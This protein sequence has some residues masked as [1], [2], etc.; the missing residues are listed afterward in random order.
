MLVRLDRNEM[1]IKLPREITDPIKESIEFL[2]R[3]TPQ[4]KV[5]ELLSSLS[6]YTNS[7]KK[8]IIISSASDI[9]LKEFIYLFSRNRQIILADPSF[10]LINATCRKIYSSILKVRLKEPEFKFSIVPLIDDLK[11][12]TLIILDNP[13]N[14]T[15]NI[16]LDKNE[17]KLI[18]E[19]ENIIFL[20]DE[21]YFEFSNVSYANLIADYPNLAILR[22]L[23]KGF[24][25]SG[26]GVGYLIGGETIQKRFLG[27]DTM[28]PYP[29]VIA[30][31]SALKNK[32]Y[33][34]EYIKEVEKEKNRIRSV[35]SKLDISVFK[36][37]SNFLLMKTKIPNISK[38]LSEQG[39]LVL[40]VSEQLGSEYFRVTIGTRK[41]NDYFLG[42]LEKITNQNRE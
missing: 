20:V 37:Y 1:S 32:N 24:G 38:K 9:L 12:P 41:E 30:G 28:L 3:Y 10:F 29:N 21:A 26:L 18:L 4:S 13:N 22:T 39:V 23:S 40:N 34:I 25:L 36:S 16:I 19:N 27:I 7:P 31:I 15:G 14:P 8:S 2:N 42:A 33:A 6:T 5:D 17:V 11:K 35:A